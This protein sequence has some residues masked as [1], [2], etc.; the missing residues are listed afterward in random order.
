MVLG[1]KVLDHPL[2]AS[3]VPFCSE[4]SPVKVSSDR[5]CVPVAFHLR[6]PL[7]A[8]VKSF[9]SFSSALL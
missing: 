9:A 6:H 5:L 8:R 2:S 1:N 7:Q 4:E 3:A